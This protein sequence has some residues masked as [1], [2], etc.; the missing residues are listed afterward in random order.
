MLFKLWKIPSEIVLLHFFERSVIVPIGVAESTRTVWPKSASLTKIIFKWHVSGKWEYL[1]G[2]YL[3]GT[4]LPLYH[5]I[6]WY[7]SNVC[8]GQ[9]KIKLV[10]LVSYKHLFLKKGAKIFFVVLDVIISLFHDTDLFLYPLKISENQR[11][12]KVFRGYRTRP[13]A[14]NGIMIWFYWII[15]RKQSPVNIVNK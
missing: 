10:L 3:T 2:L 5:I 6:Q 15:F 1:Y 8:L 4:W 9:L 14:W 12:S 13:V 11:L 7:Q